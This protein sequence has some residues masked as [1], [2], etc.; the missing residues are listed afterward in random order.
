[1][2]SLYA[3]CA[4]AIAA[5]NVARQKLVQRPPAHLQQGVRSMLSVLAVDVLG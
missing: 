3:N 5:M 4:H 1:M 2:A